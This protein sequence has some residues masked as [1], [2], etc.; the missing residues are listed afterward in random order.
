MLM[1]VMEGMVLHWPDESRM[2]GRI[3]G[4]A[5]YVV[6]TEGPEEDFF[7]EGQDYKL[8][9]AP[10]GSQANKI[11]DEDALAHLIAKCGG[12]PDVPPSV[13][14]VAEQARVEAPSP[15]DSIPAPETPKKEATDGQGQQGRGARKRAR[16]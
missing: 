2:R 8:E 1:R 6:D 5:G 10:E 3:R 13:A 15:V 12:A 9:P 16:A 11:N 14:A 4:R 7:L